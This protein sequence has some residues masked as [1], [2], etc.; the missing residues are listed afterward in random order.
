MA[1]APAVH[2]LEAID[3]VPPLFIDREGE[4]TSREGALALFHRE[5]E[6]VPRNGVK[7][8]DGSLW[9]QFTD[10]ELAVEAL[11]HEAALDGAPI[12]LSD[13]HA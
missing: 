4:V 9:N 3:D 6:V 8:R 1:E 12:P 13:E 7:K 11:L 5:A 2:K 10:L